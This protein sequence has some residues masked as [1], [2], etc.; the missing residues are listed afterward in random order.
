VH[1]LLIIFEFK[2]PDIDAGRIQL[3]RYLSSEPMAK[4]G[5]WTNFGSAP[6]FNFTTAKK[7]IEFDSTGTF[8]HSTPDVLKQL[9]PIAVS[10][11]ETYSKTIFGGKQGYQLPPGFGTASNIVGLHIGNAE[12]LDDLEPLGTMPYLE[13]LI[14]GK[15]KFASSLH[16]LT[17]MPN[18]R[19]FYIY[20]A[21]ITDLEPLAAL[22][23]L[24]QLF[25]TDL[26]R[27]SDLRPLKR[28]TKLQC[29]KLQGLP[30][31][32]NAEPLLALPD[33]KAISINDSGI[34]VPPELESKS[35]Y[36]DVKGPLGMSFGF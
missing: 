3:T 14:I 25:L 31:V 4:V 28:L 11:K 23:E 30:E 24:R 34:A 35:R 6:I 2:A 21:N 29:V 8:Y 36:C 18:L 22:G 10:I 20:D 32:K 1:A 12:F 5:F 26:P 13:A 15:P 27:V 33:L 16:F 9:G 19:L 7:I 17:R